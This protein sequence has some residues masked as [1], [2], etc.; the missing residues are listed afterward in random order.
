MNGLCQSAPPHGCQSDCE[1]QCDGIFDRPEL[2]A[3]FIV[4]QRHGT[5]TA[6]MQHEV[7][8]FRG[9]TQSPHGFQQHLRFMIYEA[10]VSDK[11]FEP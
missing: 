6:V 2:L 5:F 11:V 3:T 7:Y 8:I 10:M 9:D 1:S 4:P